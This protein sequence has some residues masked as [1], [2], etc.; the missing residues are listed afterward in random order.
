[1]LPPIIGVGS[2]DARFNAFAQ[3][4]LDHRLEA[5]EKE[6]VGGK[7]HSALGVF[8]HHHGIQDGVK[9]RVE[10]REDSRQRTAALDRGQVHKAAA[11]LRVNHCAVCSCYRFCVNAPLGER[12]LISSQPSGHVHQHLSE[13][14]HG[15]GI[16]FH[17]VSEAS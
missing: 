10:D 15:V 3:E 12:L 14:N 1:M 5:E 16:A 2:C 4:R 9:E 6:R 8:A 13:D 11:A 7:S 17:V